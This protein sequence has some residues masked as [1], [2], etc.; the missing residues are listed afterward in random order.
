[1]GRRLRLY[2]G[3]FGM[4]VITLAVA[5]GGSLFY[6]FVAIGVCA[7]MAWKAVSRARR[8][9][10]LAAMVVVCQTGDGLYT[11]WKA[12]YGV[13]FDDKCLHWVDQ[14]EKPYETCELTCL[15][16]DGDVPP[17]GTDMRGERAPGDGVQKPEDK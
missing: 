8:M 12:P 16:Y 13:A 6:A 10:P 15:A 5:I 2:L 11:I 3:L 14:Y 4:A 7:S 9:L 1:M 17:A